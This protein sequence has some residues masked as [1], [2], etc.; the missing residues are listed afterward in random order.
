MVHDELM[1]TCF[2]EASTEEIEPHNEGRW[3]GGVEAIFD[4][5]FGNSMNASPDFNELLSFYMRRL[6]SMSR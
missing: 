2:G 3:T 6:V 5:L 1:S 4:S